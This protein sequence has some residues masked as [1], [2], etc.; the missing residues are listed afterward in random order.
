MPP[1]SDRHPVDL[2]CGG[3]LIAV[4]VIDFYTARSLS[5]VAYVEPWQVAVVQVIELGLS[6]L[7]ALGVVAVV[8][9]WPLL[10]RRIHRRLTLSVLSL[11]TVGL[12]LDVMGLVASTLFGQRA[13]PIYLLL[14]VALVHASTVMLFSVWY[15]TIDH[16][17]QL[18]RPCFAFAQNAVRYPGYENWVPGFIDY[19]SLAFTTSSSLGPTEAAPLAARAKVLVMLQLGISLVILI[20]L[21]ARAIG[22]IA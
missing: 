4:S 10:R 2:A 1:G 13:N 15:A 22:L 19:V 16:H 20:V 8:A 17:R 7:S 6:T 3:A 9:G 21:A 18:G 14:E 12:V 11:Q 5:L